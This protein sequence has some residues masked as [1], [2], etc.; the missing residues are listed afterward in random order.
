MSAVPAASEPLQ[1]LVVDDDKNLA[2]TI[3]ESLER[4][5]HECTV[6]TTGKAGAAKIEQD[7]FDV[8]LT[9]LRMA[10]LD[11]LA[12]VEKVRQHQPDAEVFVITGYADVKTA[13]EAMKPRGLALFA[14][15][16]RPRRASRPSWTNR[17]NA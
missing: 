1:I 6:A 4:R 8:V 17:P 13:V 10:D 2:Q 16:N 12:I 14:E 3:A 11:G 5:G 9:D 15:A 7:K